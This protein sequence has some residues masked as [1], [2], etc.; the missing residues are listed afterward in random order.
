M[1]V[2]IIILS[3]LVIV[4]GYT[5]WNLLRKLEKHEDIA[6]GQQTYIDNISA[7]IAQSSNRLREIDEKGTFKS[8]DEVGFFFD[9]IKA[10]QD[11]LDEYKL[12]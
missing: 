5:T 3:I 7:I 4:L 9:N 10:I 1:L 12:T 6:Q 11:V 2:L 8:D